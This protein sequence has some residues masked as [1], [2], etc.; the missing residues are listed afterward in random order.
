MTTIA[1]LT[2]LSC[3]PI[4]STYVEVIG[5][6]ESLVRDR[7]QCNLDGAVNNGERS[8]AGRIYGSRL[9]KV[10]VVPIS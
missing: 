10:R 2:K 6:H 4:I 5:V 7:R 8:S 9:R 3:T 1:A